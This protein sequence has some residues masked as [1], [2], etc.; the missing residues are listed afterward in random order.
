MADRQKT[1]AEN[2]TLRLAIFG[3]LMVAAF[4]ALFSRLWFLQVLA[5]GDYEQLAQENRVRFVHSEPP[6]GRILDRNGVVIAENRTSLAVTIDRQILERRRQRKRTVEQL[7]ALLDVP[8]KQIME[9]L[10]DGTVSPYKPV[11]VVNDVNEDDAAVIEE[12]H[13]D[14]PG[15][16]IEE[17]PVRQYPESSLAAHILGYVN[18]I[19]PEQLESDHFKSVRPAYAAG[20]IVGHAG[21]EYSY[22]RFLRGEPRIEKVIVN[23][24]GDVIG[25]KLAQEERPGY[26]LVLAMDSEIQHVTEDALEAGVNA[27]RGAGYGAPGGAAVVMDPNNGDI[28]AMASFPDY[29]PRILADGIT[30]KEFKTLNDPEQNAWL[31]RAIQAQ[32]PPGSTFKVVTAG[33]AM[34]SGVAGPYDAIECPGSRVYPPEGGLGSEEFNNWTSKYFG[35]IGFATSLEISCDTFYYELGWRMEERFGPP[36]S[37][38]GDGTE[39]FQRYARRTGFDHETGID[40]PNE[41]EGRVPDKKWCNAFRKD[42]VG[43]FDGWLPG[44]T[45]NMSIGQ[46][47]LIV[48]PM[49]MAVAYSAIANGGTVWQPHVAAGLATTNDEA[50][51]DLLRPIR[52]KKVTEL[53]LDAVQLGVI[54]EGLELVISGAEGTAAGAFAGFPLDQFPLAGKTGTAEVDSGARNDAWFVSYGPS[55]APEYVVAVF[56]ED[57]GHGGESA[58]P[59]ARQIY[60]GIFGL[61]KETNVNLGTD[62]SG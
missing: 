23:S 8:A 25:S 37:R 2:V 5:A 51:V 43:C 39:R 30:T 53:P 57:A 27:A 49:Q 35:Y 60:E 55:D 20:D 15:V 4:V 19:S 31:D 9:R 62:A 16:D 54:H 6:R 14:F 38:G 28:L 29:D 45:V 21:V 3:I 50:E 41:A 42:N 13:E 58:A 12:N 22:D 17:L 44:F 11:A 18:E 56:V 40:L 48:T 26:D 61:D 52:D 7:S 34:A 10:L 24:S 32:R 47:D 1:P 59:I 36:E 46:G 33:A